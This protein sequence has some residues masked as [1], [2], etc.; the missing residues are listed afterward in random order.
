MNSPHALSEAERERRFASLRAWAVGPGELRLTAEGILLF[1]QAARTPQPPYELPPAAG[2]QVERL[3]RAGLLKGDG[4]VAQAAEEAVEAL[5]AP[6]VL[7]QLE[8]AQG[9][10]SARWLGWLGAARAFVASTDTPA[11]DPAD[12]PWQVAASP[13]AGDE[14][15][16]EIVAPGWAPLAAA[17]WLG[18][19]PRPPQPSGELRLPQSLLDHRLGDATCPPPAEAS[20]ALSVAWTQPMILWAATASPGEGAL[21]ILDA[22]AAGLWQVR[23]EDGPDGGIATLTPQSPRNVWHLLLQ[24]VIGADLTRRGL[25]H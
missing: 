25:V 7:L 3:V 17:R 5:L 13:R 21:V 11:L 10:G 19:T 14:M 1:A 20:P 15:N 4:L 18:I 6:N 22:A 2:E 23:T 24:L 12:D 8:V 9:R 16:V